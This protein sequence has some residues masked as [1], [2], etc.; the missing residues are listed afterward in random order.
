MDFYLMF[1]VCLRTISCFECVITKILNSVDEITNDGKCYENI[2]LSPLPKEPLLCSGLFGV[3]PDRVRQRS[4]LHHC[5][6]R[7][8]SSSRNNL[9][10]FCDKIIAFFGELEH[11]S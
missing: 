6:G 5:R 8:S 10:T 1:M 3:S 9:S 2:L 11:I 4:R 7:F